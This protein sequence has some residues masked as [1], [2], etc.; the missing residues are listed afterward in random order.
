MLPRAADNKL[1]TWS[2]QETW[3]SPSQQ[4]VVLVLI[5]IGRGDSR[6]R[7]PQRRQ[8]NVPHS[9]ET[10]SI[11][12]YTNYQKLLSKL[13]TMTIKRSIRNSSSSG[14][15]GVSIMEPYQK[16]PSNLGPLLSRNCVSIQDG[17]ARWVWLSALCTYVRCCFLLRTH[18]ILRISMC[19]RMGRRK[20][21]EFIKWNNNSRHCHWH[22][23]FFSIGNWH[24]NT[25]T[26]RR[27]SGMRHF[28]SRVVALILVV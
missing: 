5:I 26:H 12:N 17:L 18:R 9:T 2:Y 13:K 27:R 7:T 14:G 11:Q 25:V 19:G 23:R 16:H 21:S 22:A 8:N 20:Q 3:S 4:S 1:H 15:S 10:H 28:C 24:V 6:T